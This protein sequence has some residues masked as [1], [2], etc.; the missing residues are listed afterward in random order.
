MELFYANNYLLFTKLVGVVFLFDIILLMPFAKRYLSDPYIENSFF[1]KKNLS[2]L[3]TFLWIESAIAL[4]FSWNILIHALLFVVVYR[5]VFIDKRY[6]GLARGAGAVGYMP[7]QAALYIF[8]RECA[9]Q[10]G[11]NSQWVYLV[12]TAHLAITAWMMLNAGISKA[13]NGYLNNKGVQH[14]LV[15]PMWG[16]WPALFSKLNPNHGL[17]MVM[18]ILGVATEIGSG[19]LLW[20]PATREL[21]AII[22]ML[23]FVFVLFT[24]KLQGLCLLM[25]S[26]PILFVRDLGVYHDTVTPP[27]ILPNI[28]SHVLITVYLTICALNV[29]VSAYQFIR[30]YTPV[31]KTIRINKYIDKLAGIVPIFIWRVFT[32][33]VVNTFVKVSYRSNDRKCLMVDDKNYMFGNF[34]H[35]C[36]NYRFIHVAESVVLSTLVNQIKYNQPVE[37]LKKKFF[38]YCSTLIKPSPNDKVEWIFE[39]FEILEDKGRFYRK[40]THVIYCDPSENKFQIS[41]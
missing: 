23:I 20:F 2:Y 1:S 28:L 38:D 34:K 37:I 30:L 26:I 41:G 33:D 31:L 19:I 7:Y 25:I 27:V 4:I 14:S 18:N 36:T 35:I 10:S 5:Y 29:L 3:A 16:Y 9:M 40:L 15:N 6:K 13:L 17:F 11:I 21:G 12:D 32:Y 8:I 22:L 39:K 24:I